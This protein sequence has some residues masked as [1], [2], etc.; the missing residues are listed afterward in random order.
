VTDPL[1]R[2]VADLSRL[3][4]QAKWAHTHG[5]WKAGHGLQAEHGT[6][7]SRPEAD[8]LKGPRFDIEV[9]DHNARVAYQQACQAVTLVDVTL[10]AV[11]H[12]PQ[13]PV[14]PLTVYAR[15]HELEQ[16]ARSALDRAGRVHNPDDHRRHLN[17]AATALDRAVRSLSKAL[18]VGPADGIAHGEKMCRTCGI[19]PSADR[20][21]E[22][23]TCATWRRRNGTTRPVTLDHDVVNQ[24]RA[25]QARRMARGEGWGAA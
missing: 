9:G 17:H 23:D 7:L 2:I 12:G 15:P 25:A 3:V 10:A 19:R 22:C 20:K 24:A 11:T 5:H 18:D 21:T 13:P 14:R 16:A 1:E 4:D 8:R 6:D